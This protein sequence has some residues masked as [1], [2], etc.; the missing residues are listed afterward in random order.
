MGARVCVTEDGCQCEKT[1]ANTHTHAV[2]YQMKVTFALQ[3][4]NRCLW[5]G[6]E[7]IS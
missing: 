3:G 2:V 6:Y 1:A 4:T 5:D 7:S